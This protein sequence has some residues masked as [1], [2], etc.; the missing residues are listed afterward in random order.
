MKGLSERLI[1]IL[2]PPIKLERFDQFVLQHCESSAKQIGVK[3]G[4]VPLPD[5]HRIWRVQT[6]FSAKYIPLRRRDDNDCVRRRSQTD[7]VEQLVWLNKMLYDVGADDKVEGPRYREDVLFYVISDKLRESEALF[8][9]RYDIR[10]IHGN[11]VLTHWGDQS[12]ELE[13]WTAADIQNAP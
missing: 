8:A 5:V 2:L 4:K 10:V 9:K 1:K 13:G 11:Y 3:F 6:I 7:I 12:G